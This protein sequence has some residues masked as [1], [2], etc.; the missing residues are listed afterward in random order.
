MFT[1][2]YRRKKAVFFSLMTLFHTTARVAAGRKARGRWFCDDFQVAKFSVSIA[3]AGFSSRRQALRFYCRF[4]MYLNVKLLAVI[5][6]N[7]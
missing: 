5:G 3:L 7:L 1:T 2:T 6:F 4:V